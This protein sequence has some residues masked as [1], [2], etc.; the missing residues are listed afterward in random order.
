MLT[1]TKGNIDYCMLFDL[2][3]M[4]RVTTDIQKAQKAV[5]WLFILMYV[6][7]GIEHFLLIFLFI[8][9]KSRRDNC[10]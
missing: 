10:Y 7:N 3:S 5:H 9:K 8:V 6:I 2:I 1:Y 4:L